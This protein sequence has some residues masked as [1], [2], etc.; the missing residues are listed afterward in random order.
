MSE[1]PMNKE[2][3][4]KLEAALRAAMPYEQP[5][6]GFAERVEARIQAQ[7]VNKPGAAVIA[8]NAGWR[9]HISAARPRLAAAAVLLLAI[10]IPLGLRLQH[11]AEVAKGEAARQ[12]VL[13]A[14]RITGTQLRAIQER[15]YS[16]NTDVLQGEM[17]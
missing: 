1:Q 8:R 14:L 4:P 5:P 10:V 12:Q 7:L 2:V 17:Q 13:T 9:V 3:D 16:I 15:T 11:Q 6:A